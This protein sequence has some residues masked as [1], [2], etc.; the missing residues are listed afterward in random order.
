MANFRIF[1][2]SMLLISFDFVMSNS[3]PDEERYYVNEIKT[4]DEP[5]IISIIKERRSFVQQKDQPQ[6]RSDDTDAFPEHKPSLT[7]TTTLQPKTISKPNQVFP[8]AHHWKPETSETNSS[9]PIPVV[10]QMASP[11]DILQQGQ[12][13]N[14][15]FRNGMMPIGIAPAP[16]SPAH[17]Y[18]E[19]LSR[20]MNPFQ[21][22][23]PAFYAPSQP[24][25]E[26]DKPT[27]DN[28]DE[29][30][31]DEDAE[32]AK[33]EEDKKKEV[34]GKDGCMK[35]CEKTKTRASC[36][37]LCNSNKA[38]G[39]NTGRATFFNWNTPITSL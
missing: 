1:V 30:A 17:G 10:L 11:M 33:V 20:F 5:A 7:L 38:P 31:G 3:N 19:F 35:K 28:A 25:A 27:S 39:G 14:P 22:G 37:Y 26:S 34:A 36:T 15:M 9:A 32:A 23:L 12:M 8:P 6:Y 4:L 24:D 21:P 29:Q 16:I 13:M 18:Q 2:I